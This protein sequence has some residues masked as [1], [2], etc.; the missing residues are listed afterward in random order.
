MISQD[1]I[2]IV[3][4][5]TLEGK[6]LPRQSASG[7]IPGV[8]R[9]PDGKPLLPLEAPTLY[10]FGHL[11]RCTERL[12]LELFTQGLLSGT[13]HTCLGQ[14]LC[15]MA[16]VR[17]LDDPHDVRP[18]E[19][20]QPRPFP[21]LFGRFSRSRRGNHGPRARRVQWRR[22]QPAPRLPTLSQQRRAGRHDRHS[23]RAR[24]RREDARRPGHRGVRHRRRHAW[25]RG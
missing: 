1:S 7:L 25:A 18:V 20:S 14:E 5:K 15:Q 2:T 16:V 13:T 9:D 12:L 22:R 21:H 23:V 11:I 10:A 4:A 8:E 17:A 6:E 19:P 3:R 24:A